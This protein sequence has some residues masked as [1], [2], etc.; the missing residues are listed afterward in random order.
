MVGMSRITVEDLQIEK[1]KVEEFARA[2]WD[3]NPIYRSEE[4]AAEQGFDA[5]PAPLTFARIRM[6]PRY[7][8][9]ELLGEKRR[10][11]TGSIPFMA[12]KSTSTNDRYTWARR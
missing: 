11:S 4:V 10:G 8:P 12:S 9:P 1:G 7:C 5:I 3:K 6:F 2:V